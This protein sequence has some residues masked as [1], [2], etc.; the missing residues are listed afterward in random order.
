MIRYIPT[1]DL[2]ESEILTL[3][4]AYTLS[5]LNLIPKDPY[6]ELLLTVLHHRLP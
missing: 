6:C 2:T 3:K 1:H 4:L 5:K